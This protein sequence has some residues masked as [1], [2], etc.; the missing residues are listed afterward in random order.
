MNGRQKLESPVKKKK[1]FK[2]KKYIYKK[3]NKRL[4]CLYTKHYT[5]V[6][7]MI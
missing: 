2:R 7:S 6:L 1:D 5:V 3:L 4:T